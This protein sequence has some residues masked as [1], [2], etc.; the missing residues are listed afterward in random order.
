MNA[1]HPG[2]CRGG[3]ELGGNPVSNF[4]VGPKPP[5]NARK[6]SRGVFIHK[7]RALRGQLYSQGEPFMVNGLV[8]RRPLL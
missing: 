1:N 3:R 5:L 6:R 2:T 4:L 8:A 7:S